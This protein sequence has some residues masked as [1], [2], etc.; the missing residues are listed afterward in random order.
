MM[1]IMKIWEKVRKK[2][3][4]KEIDALGGITATAVDHAGIQFRTLNSSKGPAVRA[5]RAQTDR[6]L[7][8]IEI[9]KIL[10]NYPHLHIFQQPCTQLLF[11]GNKVIG[12]ETEAGIKIRAKTVILC[13]G[14]FLNGLIHI[15]L[16]HYSGGR[17]G[18][19]AAIKLAEQMHSYPIRMGRLKT[20]TPCRIDKRTVDF[21]KLQKQEPDEEIPVFSFMG[22]KKD[23]PQQISCYIAKTNEKTHDIIDIPVDN[24]SNPSIKFIAFVIPIIHP[25][26]NI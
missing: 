1:K 21:S 7:Y 22:K 23:H 26:V 16:K 2:E 17:A 8:K 19:Q 18:E 12:A 6:V 10:E 20:G 4:I 24:P 25:I 15:G 14:T 5:T 13:T 3:N 11:D 9:R